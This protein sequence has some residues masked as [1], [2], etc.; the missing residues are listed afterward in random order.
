MGG[1]YLPGEPKYDFPSFVEVLLMLALC[2]PPP[3]HLEPIEERL[4]RID[5][6]LGGFL[7]LPEIGMDKSW[8]IQHAFREDQDDAEDDPR[9][10]DAERIFLEMDDDLAEL[11]EKPQARLPGPAADA[12]LAPPRPTI[13]EIQE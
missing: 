6:V 11:P 12:K 1:A 13:E 2:S 4:Q 5:Q 9:E 3:V 8:T 7:G 10:W